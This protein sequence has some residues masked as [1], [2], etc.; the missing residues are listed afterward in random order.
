MPTVLPIHV[1]V[2]CMYICGY[3]VYTWVSDILVYMLLTRS[4]GP[5]VHRVNKVKK[6]IHFRNGHCIAYTCV[7][8]L[9]VYM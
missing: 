3:L 5:Q 9:F 1:W 2:V 7:G 4:G 8:G 6:K